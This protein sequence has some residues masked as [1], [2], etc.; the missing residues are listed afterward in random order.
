MNSL[1]LRTCKTVALALLDVFR[2][3]NVQHLP[4]KV[5]D[6]LYDKTEQRVLEAQNT[7]S[8]SV[9]CI[10]A[11]SV[12]EPATQ[13][14]LNTFHLAGCATKNVTLGIPRLK[15][16]LDAARH[17]KTP[18]TTIRF[19]RPYSASKEFVEYFANTPSLTRLGDIV[20]ETK[21]VAVRDGTTRTTCG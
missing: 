10:A 16:L 9:G 13:M 1:R 14:T 18:C 21:I 6:S 7:R 11:Q 4:Q 5:F 15:E 3:S 12:G 17:A 8:E 2:E 19:Y 20:C